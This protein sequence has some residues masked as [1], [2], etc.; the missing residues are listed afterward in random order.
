MSVHKSSHKV[1]VKD[2]ASLV[3]SNQP[4]GSKFAL[5]AP[6]MGIGPEIHARNK[7]IYLGDLKRRSNKLFSE[8]NTSTKQHQYNN[9]SK[10]YNKLL[11]DPNFPQEFK[12]KGTTNGYIF[13]VMIFD[14][15][16][17]QQIFEN[18]I[19]MDEYWVDISQEKEINYYLSIIKALSQTGG[20]KN[21]KKKNKT[22]KRTKK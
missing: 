21:S 10:L 12:D 6:D 15:S 5:T 1:T 17:P 11:K 18:I 7:E 8:I 3:A 13:S 22:I 14:I 2:I 19:A 20:G 16:T 4:V 9:R